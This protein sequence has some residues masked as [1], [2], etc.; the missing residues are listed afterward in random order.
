MIK[1]K[2]KKLLLLDGNAIVHRAFHGI[3]PLTTQSGLQVNAVYG[4]TATF[5][6]VLEKFQPDYIV[7]TFDLP[8][9]TFRHEKFSDYK[10]NRK[11]T[12]E[13]L[14]PQFTLVKDVMKAFNI[15]ILEKAGFEADDIIGTLSVQASEKNLETIIVTGDKDTLQLVDDQVKVF[16]MS[17]GIND[18]LLYDQEMVK[19]KMGVLPDQ[20]I[21]Y[22]GLRGDASD[23]I[24]G[25]KGVGD[26]TA[27]TLLQEYPTLEKIYENL[28][29]IKE[30]VR[31][32][33]IADKE[34][35]FL[36]RELGVILT[37]VPVK[38][39]LKKADVNQISF[40][41]ARKI[42][43]EFEF[44]RLIKRLPDNGEF[45]EKNKN[46]NQFTILDSSNIS[47]IVES[48]SKKMIGVFPDVEDSIFYGLGLATEKENFYLPFDKK[49][50]EIF[51]EFLLNEE[52]EKTFFDVKNLL[53]ILDKN[54][55][56]LKKIDSDILLEAY[57]CRTG[58]KIVLDDLIFEVTGRV[59]SPEKKSNQMAL[60]LRNEKKAQQEVCQ[61][62][63]DILLIHDFFTKEIKSIAKQQNKEKNIKS[64]LENLEMPLVQILFDM[65]KNGVAFD[66]KIF[67]E[68][69][70]DFNKKIGKLE[71]DIYKMA[72]EEF[73]INSTKQLRVILFEK[74]K[75][76]TTNIKK[77]KTGFS[78]A[79]SELEKIKEM[80]PIA[81]KIEKYRELFKLKTTYVDALPKLTDSN[82][83]IHT[84]FNQAI[85]ATGRLSSSE[86]NLQNIPIRTET[87]RR[88]RKGFVAEK[89]FKLVSADYSQIDLRCIAHVSQDK[90]LIQAF[91]NNMDI[92][93]FTAATVRGKDVSEVSKTERSAAKELNFGLIYGMGSFGFSRA[94]GITV[95]EAKDFIKKYFEK[96]PEVKK[97]IEQTKKEV[98]ENG[99]VE[100]EMGR[101]RNVPEI[102][103]K[104][105]Q[106]RTMGER[107]AVNMPIQGLAADIMKLA[108][109]GVFDYLKDNF[110]S[111]EAR[112]ILQIHDE[113]ILEV[114]DDLVE[115]V[116]EDIRKIMEEVYKFSVPLVVDIAVG[117]DWGEL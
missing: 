6:N 39:D 16:T 100:T 41:G 52:I 12:A 107:M 38:L 24:P 49:N 9:K 4:F 40:D 115:R 18:M 95:E 26:K 20:V 111:D 56:S 22:K 75:I 88:L 81:L 104:N 27:L 108:M 1:N 46:A 84:T 28:D 23:N 67:E 58:K 48:F 78:T 112:M 17:R 90:N 98:E 42:F 85:T 69:A 45:E 96:F 13:D 73:N 65:E 54:D 89:G 77:T 109:I 74:L 3:P 25:V 106:L 80:H 79:S 94:A 33:L 36:S 92:H 72:G 76:D 19:D 57:V 8:G 34:K 2:S 43:H 101:R 86:P 68:I 31:K 29:N 113:V 99:F 30:S 83:R 71:K 11:A 93:S 63:K 32:K 87:G 110:E 5:L 114:Q 44:K 47:K 61:K 21:E 82:N 50:K 14:I 7:A 37:N 10:A 91:K 60:N 102:Q 64:L 51:Q 70:K 97:Y 53:H 66:S 15:A 117:V 105:F 103:S 116:S 35:A 62:A 55:L 59:V